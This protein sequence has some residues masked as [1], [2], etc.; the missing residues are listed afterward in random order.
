MRKWKENEEMKR[1][2]RESGE[3]E[4]KRKENEEME[5]DFLSFKQFPL[6]YYI[7]ICNGICKDLYNKF[8]FGKNRQTLFDI[9]EEVEVRMRQL[10][11][12]STTRFANSI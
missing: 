9:C 6:Y 3:I 10:A 1:K 4:R 7:D 8:N 5:R 11:N 12:F 2:W